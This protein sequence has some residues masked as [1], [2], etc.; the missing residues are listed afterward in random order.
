MIV[1]SAETLDDAFD[2][3]E[4]LLRILIAVYC[5]TVARQVP[6]VGAELCHI[7]IRG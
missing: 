4:T 6:Q 7:L 2:V 5:E 3:E 1:P